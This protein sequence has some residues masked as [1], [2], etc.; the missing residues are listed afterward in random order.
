MSPDLLSKPDHKPLAHCE[1]ADYLDTEV[2][3]I[4]TSGV[5]T[6]PENASLH[7]VYRTLVTHQIHSV[8][9]VGQT[10]F[11]PLG[12]VTAR[13]LLTWLC[14]DHTAPRSHV[15]WLNGDDGMT[16]ARDAIT[17]EPVSI[18]AWSTAREAVSGLQQPGVSLLLVSARPDLPP[19][20][21]LSDLDLVALA[22][23]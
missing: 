21:V 8:L 9:V 22:A 23:R 12:W 13:G 2:G 4:M 19:E 17:Q 16:C 5:V 6:I 14:R 10:T 1:S 15:S 11:K 7:E 18:P 20:G 3:H